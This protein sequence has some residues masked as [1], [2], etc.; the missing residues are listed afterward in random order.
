[1][2]PG[3]KKT[4]QSISMEALESPRTL[5]QRKKAQL[6]PMAHMGKLC[7]IKCMLVHRH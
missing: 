1:M 3:E 2:I 6:V 5:L 7:G 4:S